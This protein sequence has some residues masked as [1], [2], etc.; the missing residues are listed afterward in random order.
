[1]R[2]YYYRAFYAG[3]P[4][5]AAAMSNIARVV[6]RQ[7]ALLRPTNLGS[8]DDVSVGTT[9]R[10]TTT[11]RPARPELPRAIVTFVAYRLIGRTWTLVGTRD[12]L[13]DASGL[14]AVDVTFSQP[15]RWYVR[16]IARPTTVNANSV[17]S[18]VE[19][20]DVR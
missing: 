10:F 17:W 19:R 9:I 6:V 14:A 2:N 8:V 13:I 5:L 16:S 15:G 12:V 4:D 1:M 20:Y 11:V 7:I 3:A 18:P